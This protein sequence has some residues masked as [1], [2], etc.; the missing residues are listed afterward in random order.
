MEAIQRVQVLRLST[1][2][3]AKSLLD[4][5]QSRAC[6]QGDAIFQVAG[7]RIERWTEIASVAA[8]M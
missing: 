5:G 6:V 1:I 3:L 4:A 7:G 8:P 2:A